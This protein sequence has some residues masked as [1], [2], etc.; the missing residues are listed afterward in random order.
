M[1]VPESGQSVFDRE[2]G[3][4]PQDNY[5]PVMVN[6]IVTSLSMTIEEGRGYRFHPLS[7][8][9]QMVTGLHGQG[10]SRKAGECSAVS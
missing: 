10:C 9:R 1:P 7:C 4:R 6:R 8:H 3:I 5:I 2:I